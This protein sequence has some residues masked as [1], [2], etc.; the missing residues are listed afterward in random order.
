MKEKNDMLDS[1]GAGKDDS[2]LLQ[3][4]KIW[5]RP[6]II[7]LDAVEGTQGDSYQAGDGISNLS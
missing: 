3:E 1:G 2:K 6:V 4:K 7:S 5:H